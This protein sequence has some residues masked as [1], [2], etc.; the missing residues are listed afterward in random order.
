[1]EKNWMKEKWKQCNAARKNGIRNRETFFF[2][3]NGI[4]IL[5]ESFQTMIFSAFLFLNNE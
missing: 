2:W 5:A 4:N 3:N 1:M